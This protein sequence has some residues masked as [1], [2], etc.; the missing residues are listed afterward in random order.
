M[1]NGMIFPFKTTWRARLDLEYLDENSDR[2]H[3]L[4][5]YYGDLSD[6]SAVGKKL[7]Q[8]A[9]YASK[10]TLGQVHAGGFFH[11]QIIGNL[12]GTRSAP[13]QLSNA[14]RKR[15][16]SIAWFNHLQK[17]PTTSE[18]PIIQHRLV[19]TM[20][21]P[22]HDKLVETGINPD[23][24]LQVTMK[25]VI[26]KFAEKFHPNDAV[27]YAYGIHHDTDHL[28]IHVA[29]CPRSAKGAYVGCS[30]SRTKE[31]GNKN[32]MSYLM[33]CFELENQRWSQSLDSPDKL[34]QQLSKRYDSEKI[35]FAP[36]LTNS[37][38]EALRNTQTAEAIRL[39]Q[40]YQSIRNLEAAIAAKRQ[41]LTAKR[42]TN[43]LARMLG[44]RKPKLTRTVEKLAAQV[45]RR[46][47]RE[48]QSLLFKI[49][50]EYRATHKR[51][52]QTHGFH[53]YGHRSSITHSQRQQVTQS[54]FVLC[55]NFVFRPANVDGFSHQNYADGSSVTTVNFKSYTQS[56]PDPE[57]HLFDFLISKLNPESTDETH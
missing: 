52:T 33:K 18:N 27:G 15:R 42:N 56:I 36:R 30:M 2:K 6:Q 10:E 22:F 40:A 47:L 4:R 41:L 21:K 32:Q 31:S 39:Q 7:K 11:H 12:D 57:R 5:R 16:I 13:S 46:S 26:R 19:F 17:F 29:L 3:S 28:H 8:F 43:Y 54:D 25:K 48:M 49:K 51:Y 55:E 34:Q 14:E 45:D 24:V 1:K 53:S 20:S 35:L 37:H 44:R 23:R 9:E 50:R 38:L